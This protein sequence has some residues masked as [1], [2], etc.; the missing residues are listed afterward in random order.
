MP[1]RT[2][3]MTAPCEPCEGDGQ[4]TSG[5]ATED[6]PTCGGTGV[7]LVRE[8]VIDADHIEHYLESLMGS[9]A[10]RRD[11]WEQEVKDVARQ[12]RGRIGAENLT[13]DVGP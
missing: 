10:G 8:H 11:G 3:K 9:M 6:C 1:T 13:V 4:L 2:V 5:I 12:G 7:R